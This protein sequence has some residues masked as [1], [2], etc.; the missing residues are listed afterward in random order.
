M[1]NLWKHPVSSW[2]GG[3]R[4]LIHPPF[5]IRQ[6][7]NKPVSFYSSS[8]PKRTPSDEYVPL[9]APE[10]E[11]MRELLQKGYQVWEIALNIGR[12]EWVVR[13]SLKEDDELASHLRKVKIGKWSSVEESFLL[14]YM[15]K[16]S[17]LNRQK[18][19][20]R[21]GRTVPSVTSQIRK[22]A[23]AQSSLTPPLPVI[24]HPD[25]ELS[26]SER[27]TLED[28]LDRILEGLTEAKKTA[29]WDSILAGTPRAEWIERILALVPTRI[30]HILA[31]PSPP[32]IPELRALDWEDTDKMGVYAWILACKT[33][34]PFFPKHYIYV[35]SATRYGSGLSGRKQQHQNGAKHDDPS[36]KRRIKAHGLDR[37]GHFV[38]LLSMEVASPEPSEVMKAREFIVV[39]K[40]VFTIWLG[41]LSSNISQTSREDAKTEHDKLRGLCPWSL[42]P[43]PY[44]GLCSH[45][46]LVVDISYPK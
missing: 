10:T 28:R 46:P 33:Q 20:Q 44:R 15:A 18:I 38:A 34:N 12:S 16:H 14:G 1:A 27:A 3:G 2:R 8:P 5:N 32:T 23:K 7:N 4:G 22:L 29:K 37:K 35:G 9:T 30:G 19:A 43:I 39:A 45:N 11:L 13:R 26:E 42:E 17:V 6:C 21:M 41:A 36:L 40:A 24:I 25:G 31:A